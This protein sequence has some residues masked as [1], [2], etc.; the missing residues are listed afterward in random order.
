M[1]YKRLR[2]R[3]SI[4][5]A[6]NPSTKGIS[7]PANTGNDDSWNVSQRLREEPQTDLLFAI[8]N[9]SD[10]AIISKDLNG[11]V[12]TWNQGAERLFGYTAEEAIGRMIAEL[13]IPD[14]RQA[15]EPE[16]LARMR[17]GERIDHFETVRRRKDGSLLDISLTI[18]PVKDQSGTIIGASKIARDITDR[19]R[20]EKAMT[21]LNAQLKADLAAMARM[22]QLSTRLIQAGAFSELLEEILTAGIEITGADMGAIQLLDKH[23]ALRIVA[24]RGLNAQFL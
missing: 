3:K 16:I 19:K 18:S 8:V 7:L 4:C 17:R 11:V 6:P 5:A 22:Q 2:V 15:E 13:V 10:D 20:A 9:S 21:S 12:T 1:L 24:H 23:D 14:D